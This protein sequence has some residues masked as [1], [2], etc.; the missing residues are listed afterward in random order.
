M[1]WPPACVVVRSYVDQ[2]VRGNGLTADR[3]AA[4]T[5]ALDAAEMKAGPARAT[6]L[7]ALA[8]QVDGD[9]KSAKDAARVRTMASEIRRLAT[10]SK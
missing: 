4:I 1:T 10:A 2:L 9:A 6:A 8:L 5:A 7:K 3:T